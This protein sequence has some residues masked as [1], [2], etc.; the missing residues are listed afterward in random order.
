[1]AL[2]RLRDA[3]PDDLETLWNLDQKC[4]EPGI[5]YSAGE[6]RRFLRLPSVQTLVAELKGRVAGFITGYLRGGVA[7]IVTVDVD[8]DCRRQGLGK[9]LMEEWISRLLRAGAREVRLEVDVG[10]DGA[11]AFYRNLGF[12]KLRRLENYY[13][14]GRDA[15]EMRRAVAPASAIS[16]RSF[17]SGSA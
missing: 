17:R 11:I 2:E 9:R 15:F 8:P 4:F 7:R 1:M 6:L 10:N 16:G 14:P 13:G 5:A 12:R 3:F